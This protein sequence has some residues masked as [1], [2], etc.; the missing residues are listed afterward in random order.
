MDTQLACVEKGG[1][2]TL[3]VPQPS[4]RPSEPQT[5]PLHGSGPNHSAGTPGP[6]GMCN[7]AAHRTTQQVIGLPLQSTG[8]MLWVVR[9]KQYRHGAARAYTTLPRVC[10]A[11]GCEPKLGQCASMS[12]CSMQWGCPAMQRLQLVA[13]V[14]TLFRFC[15]F[16]SSFVSSA[17]RW[18]AHEKVREEPG[19]LG[20]RWRGG[21]TSWLV[22]NP[23]CIAGVD[24]SRR[25]TALD[26]AG[27]M[28][29][30][31][32]WEANVVHAPSSDSP[33]RNLSLPTN[34][35]LGSA[36][37]PSGSFG[38]YAPA[39]AEHSKQDNKI[40]RS[41]E[42]AGKQRCPSYVPQRT[43][44]WHICF[45]VPPALRRFA[46]VRH[47]S[48]CSYVHHEYLAHCQVPAPGWMASAL[49]SRMRRRRPARTV[50]HHGHQGCTVMQI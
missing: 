5:A 19:L 9:A 3:Y 18:V 46:P 24:E 50:E 38:S 34:A 4:G 7:T 49:Y 10:P 26:A 32:G 44:A 29:S 48:L 37:Q 42:V 13:S 2:T 21:D 40:L 20:C 23:A 8:C 22:S 25:G 17:M 41:C 39:F 45:R 36:F 35:D 12:S 11:A 33:G 27:G 47:C 16:C 31:C 28:R 15:A 43:W 1:C 6:V 30:R 14:P